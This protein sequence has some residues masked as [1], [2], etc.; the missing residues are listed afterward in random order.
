MTLPILSRQSFQTPCTIE[1][2]HTADHLHA[3]V[4][5]ADGLRP[6]PGDRVLVHGDPIHIPF[7]ERRVLSR[8][9][10]VERATWIERLWTR[11]SATMLLT[12]LYE[13]SFTSR[14]RL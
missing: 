14:R 6:E 10:T 13:V 4:E 12:E 5:L 1:I 8:V 11:L 2:E 3:H 9:A 7:G